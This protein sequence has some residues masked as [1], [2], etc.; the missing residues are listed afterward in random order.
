MRAL[1]LLVLLCT[2][3][4]PSGEPILGVRDTDTGPSARIH[5][6]SKPRYREITD[7][8]GVQRGWK[9]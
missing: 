7:E 9:F 3:C 6:E 1:L 5:G 8:L 2:G 4:S